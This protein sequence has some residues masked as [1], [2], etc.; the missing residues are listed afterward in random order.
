MKTFQWRN[1]GCSWK[2][3]SFLC[4]KLRA[5]PHKF[6]RCCRCLLFIRQKSSFLIQVATLIILSRA[7]SKFQSTAASRLCRQSLS[8]RLSPLKQ[9]VTGGCQLGIKFFRSWPSHA[10]STRTKKAWHL[11]S[12]K[13][14]PF[15]WKIQSRNEVQI[16]IV[17]S[18]RTTGEWL[19][20]KWNPLCKL[21]MQLTSLPRSSAPASEEKARRSFTQTKLRIRIIPGIWIICPARSTVWCSF[22][23]SRT[24]V[25]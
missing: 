21:S 4:S 9:R 25:A 14:W 1:K 22:H 20:S 7:L 5:W 23:E 16:C 17:K 12:L 6:Q 3:C 24:L 13:R 18:K 15:N 2:H 11:K 10:P 8:S 19:T